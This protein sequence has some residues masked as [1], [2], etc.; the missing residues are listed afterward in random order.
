MKMTDQQKQAVGLWVQI[1]TAILVTVL[2]GIFAFTFTVT[3]D[4]TKRIMD[5]EKRL[6]AYDMRTEMLN[7]SL[8]EIK[9]NIKSLDIKIDC[10]REQLT[11]VDKRLARIER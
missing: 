10:L 1:V 8:R 3:Q 9:E 6:A 5:I 7:L 2:I 4:N 11:G